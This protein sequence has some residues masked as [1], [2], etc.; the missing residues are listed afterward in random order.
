MRKKILLVTI[1][2]VFVSLALEA[3]SSVA[4]TEEAVSDS[5]T[6]LESAEPAFKIGYFAFP[7][8]SPSMLAVQ[9]NEVY[10]NAVMGGEAVFVELNDFSSE[11]MIDAVEQLIQMGVDAIFICPLTEAPMAKIAQLCDEAGV[12]FGWNHRQMYDEEIRE[13][14]TSSEYFVGYAVENEY[15]AAYNAVQHMSES[16]IEYIA[17]ITE[18]L[19]DTVAAERERGTRA[20]AEDLGV[21]IVGEVRGLTQGTEVTTAVESFIAAYPEL[22]LV[23]WSNGYQD[24]CFGFLGWF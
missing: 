24:G 22:Q 18:D 7:G 19:S 17:L 5:S 8:E 4:E 15:E 21:T 10:M 1:L 13:L 20:A 16:G 2:L 11:G 3:C 14:V 6:A 12:Y 9:A 23:F